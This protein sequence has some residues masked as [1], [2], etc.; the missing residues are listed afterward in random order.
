MC[1]GGT[2]AT[3]ASVAFSGRVD[4][5]KTALPAAREWTSTGA[6]LHVTCRGTRIGRN[7]LARVPSRR[8]ILAGSTV[9]TCQFG[10]GS[11]AQRADHLLG[12]GEFGGEEAIAAWSGNRTPKGADD[13]RA[14]R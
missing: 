11:G 12:R 1:M 5:I 2:T 9:K 7:E 13:L 14:C 8:R 3:A 6:D 10:E 4:T